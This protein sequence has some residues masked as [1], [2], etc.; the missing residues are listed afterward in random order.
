VNGRYGRQSGHRSQSR[1]GPQTMLAVSSFVS[2]GVRENQPQFS[3]QAL[4][5]FRTPNPS[6]RFSPYGRLR[7]S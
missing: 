1:R 5:D 6:A 7:F 3:R 2:S 4:P